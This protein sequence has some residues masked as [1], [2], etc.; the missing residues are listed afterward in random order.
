MVGAIVSVGVVTNGA[1]FG[2]IVEVTAVEAITRVAEEPNIVPVLAVVVIT[3]V[4][5]RMDVVV[6][7]IAALVFIIVVL[8]LAKF[9]NTSY[10]I[11][12]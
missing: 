1:A 8:H 11:V 7:S 10:D 12:A 3:T 6:R 4:V 2:I 9:I 5:G